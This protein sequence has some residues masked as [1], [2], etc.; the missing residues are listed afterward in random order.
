MY[1][2]IIKLWKKKKQ[3]ETPLVPN[4]LEEEHTGWIFYPDV[5]SETCRSVDSWAELRAFD[6]FSLSKL[7]FASDTWKKGEEIHLKGR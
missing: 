6:K 1:S 3:S 5:A 2:D 4:T 7:E